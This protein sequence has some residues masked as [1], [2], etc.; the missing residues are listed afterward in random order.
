M[1]TQTQGEPLREDGQTFAEMFEE[2]LQRQD[3][4]REGEIVRGK[5]IE[6]GGDKV[7]V[8]IGYKSEA[9]VS[10]S[11]FSIIDGKASVTVGQEIDLYVESR[12]DDTGLV[13]VSKEKADKLRVWDD[14]SAAAERD[15][16]ID[17]VVVA[18]VK[19]GL[20]V[21]I[22]VKAFLPGSQ[23]DLRPIRNLDKLIG[24][25]FKFKVIKFNKKR[26]NIVLSRRV[27]LEQ[28]REEHKRETLKNLAEGEV[29]V[30]VVKNL[31]D[32]GAFV[33]LGGIDGL[34]H[35]T[36]MSWGRINH[37]SEMFNISDE[38][39]VKVLKFDADTERVSL[40]YKQI[41]EDPWAN[42]AEKYP[43]GVHVEGKVVSLTDYGAFIEIEPGVEGLV[44]VS[45]MSWTKRVKHPS[46]IVE[47]GH[48]VKAIVLD[49]D[50][51]QKRISLGMK[52]I[53]P[54]P[55]TQLADKYPVGAVIKGTVRNITDFGIFVGVEEGIDGLVHV[56]DLSW[57]HRVKHPSELYTKGDEVEAVVLNIDV[58]NERFS[59]GIKQLT[60]DPWETLPRRFPRGTKVIGK[61]MKITDYGVFVEIEPGIDGLCH[62]SEL[63]DERVEKVSDITKQGDDVEVMVLDVDPGERRISL[64]IKAARDGTSDYRAYMGNEAIGRAQLGDVFGEKLAAVVNTDED[65]SDYKDSSED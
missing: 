47:V 23:V 50:L 43:V 12:E 2:S 46:K 34:L 49:I 45:E 9:T 8:D 54:N 26:G 37:P 59:L 22:G 32:Y 27:L 51:P 31:T 11:E 7:L 38:I 4:V 65:G 53:E 18:R 17:G 20:S 52:Q 29:M 16:L 57:T 35:I 33:D 41:T 14:I 25:R 62:I 40:G 56:S 60:D 28:E 21:D 19:G 6:V 64:S 10:L 24:Q 42:A 61:V 15:E 58:E 3:A 48:E 55:W 36:D 63:A 5:V 30:G 44:H 13:I 39:K 1:D